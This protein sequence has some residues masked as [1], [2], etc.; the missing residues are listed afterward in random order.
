[1]HAVCAFFEKLDFRRSNTPKPGNRT[2]RPRPGRTGRLLRWH[3]TADHCYIFNSFWRIQ[4]MRQSLFLY[5]FP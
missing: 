3:T 4:N 2:Q 5:K 1:V